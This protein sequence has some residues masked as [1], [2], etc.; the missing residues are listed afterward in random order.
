MRLLIPAVLLLAACEPD[1]PAPSDV[2]GTWLLHSVVMTQEG[3]DDPAFPSYHSPANGTHAWALTWGSS[4][5]GDVD[6]K[7]DGR[8]MSGVGAW[9]PY[10]C[11]AFS[12]DVS[13]THMGETGTRHAFEATLNLVLWDDRL[14]GAYEWAEDWT[15]REG[16][17]SGTFTAQGRMSGTRP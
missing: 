16:S 10:A 3:G 5:L 9:D 14:D 1:C 17:Q 11:G 12:L 13:G 2:D 8:D 4:E 7:L 15:D 6:V